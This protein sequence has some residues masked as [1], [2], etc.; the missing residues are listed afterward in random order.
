MKKCYIFDLD[1]TLADS[2]GWWYSSFSEDERCDEERMNEVRRLMKTRYADIIGPKSGA[3]ELLELLRSRGVRMC[4]ASATDKW[5]SEPFMKKYGLEK[6]FE[7]YI[8]CTEAG[9]RKDKP[10][11]YLQAA[12]RLGASPEECVVVEDSAY[13]A[14][15]AHNAGFTVVGVYDKNTA[16]RGDVSEFADIFVQE[17]DEY[18]KMI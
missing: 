14:E 4:I 11:I 1:G 2:M 12:Q 10:D 3:L 7:F 13:C 5:V 15:T 16:P 8:D 6:Y 17:L 9:A 18:I